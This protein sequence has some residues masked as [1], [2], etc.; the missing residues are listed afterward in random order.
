[1]T[2]RPITPLTVHRQKVTHPMPYNDDT[3]THDEWY[4]LRENDRHWIDAIV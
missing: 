3:S 4:P 2:E 1:M